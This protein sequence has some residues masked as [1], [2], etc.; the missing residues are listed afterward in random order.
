MGR[1]LH[2]GNLQL[3]A[4]SH[5]QNS[6]GVVEGYNE[7]QVG[8]VAVRV[9]ITTPGL[10]IAAINNVWKRFFCIVSLLS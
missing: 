7:A 8:V 5:Q 9:A 2:F 10:N 6:Q 4:E 1:H 3:L